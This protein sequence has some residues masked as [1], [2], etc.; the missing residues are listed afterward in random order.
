MGEIN[1]SAV[2]SSENSVSAWLP[3]ED[4]VGDLA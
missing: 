3:T 2:K 1:L 4:V